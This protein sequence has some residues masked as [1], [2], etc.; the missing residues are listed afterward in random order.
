MVSH[1]R[2]FLERVTDSTWALLGDGQVSMLPG[3]VDE[4]LRRLPQF[5]RGVADDRENRAEASQIPGDAPARAGSAEER[6]ARKALARI[7]RQLEKLAE[8]EAALH[9]QLGAH[10][11]DYERLAELTAEL[12]RLAAEKDALEQEWLEVAALLE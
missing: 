4:Y 12:G 1:D 5:R 3:G 2:Y 6:D 10:Q 8:T 7:D 9:Q 11:S